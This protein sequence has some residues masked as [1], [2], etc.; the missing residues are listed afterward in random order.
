MSHHYLC[1]MPIVKIQS[2]SSETIAN[3]GTVSC[4]RHSVYVVIVIVRNKS[5]QKC[6]QW[7]FSILRM[8]HTLEFQISDNI[9]GNEKKERDN[10]SW[11]TSQFFVV[12]PTLSDLAIL[13]RLGL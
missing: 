3:V 4:F 7:L 5:S 2:E 11:F 9:S 6:L 13:C 8:I 12:D 1:T 10:F